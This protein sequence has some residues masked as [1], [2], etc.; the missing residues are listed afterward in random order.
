MLP[1]ETSKMGKPKENDVRESGCCVGENT[2]LGNS[3]CKYIFQHFA[4]QVKV[5]GELPQETLFQ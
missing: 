5:Q 2:A 3:L 4:A 1:R